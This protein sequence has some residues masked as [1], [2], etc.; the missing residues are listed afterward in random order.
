MVLGGLRFGLR[1]PTLDEDLG[2][3]IDV[4]HEKIEV[5]NYSGYTVVS[6]GVL[7]PHHAW[8]SFLVQDRSGFMPFGG[9]HIG[10]D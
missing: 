8:Y 7:K 3:C 10:T 1:P 5:E 2:G 6:D 4:R 9:N